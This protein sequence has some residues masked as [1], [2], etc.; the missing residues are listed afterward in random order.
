MGYNNFVLKICMF[1]HSKCKVRLN[2]ELF[3]AII[4]WD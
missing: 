4:V 1:Q 2:K 3:A